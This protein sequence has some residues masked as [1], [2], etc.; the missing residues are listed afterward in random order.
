MTPLPEEITQMLVAWRNGD[1]EALNRL[2]PLVYDELRRLAHRYMNRR[3]A[4][5]T[6]QTTAL[7]HEAYLRLAGQDHLALQNRSHF[8]AVCAQVMRNLLV[9]QARS[10][11]VAKHGGDWRRVSLDE[12]AVLTLEKQIDMLAKVLLISIIPPSALPAPM[13]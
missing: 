1:P 3:F 8:F 7:I 9:D 11:Q 12:A 13:R 4:G 5:Q 6:M 10:R 2:M